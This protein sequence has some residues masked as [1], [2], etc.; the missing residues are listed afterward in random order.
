[1]GEGG[2]SCTEQFD[3]KTFWLGRIDAAEDTLALIGKDFD[4]GSVD[5]DAQVKQFAVVEV[6]GSGLGGL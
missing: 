1:V 5:Q 3:L 6:K 2:T 4:N